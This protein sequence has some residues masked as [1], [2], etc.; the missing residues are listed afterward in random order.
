LRRSPGQPPRR[1]EVP[2]SSQDI[3]PTLLR[4]LDEPGFESFLERSLGHDVLA[5][6][7]TPQPI[8]SQDTGRARD[9]PFKRAL[10]DRN[11]KYLRIEH[12]DGRIEERLFDLGVD[13]YE[14]RDVAT[15]H[16][17]LLESMRE[18]ALALID[19]HSRRG[20][21]LRAG[22]EQVV[23]QEAD[24]KLLRELCALGYL[25]P[26]RCAALESGSAG[27]VPSADSAVEGGDSS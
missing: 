10:V 5:D 21:A 9:E 8:L 6:D 17:E 18:R 14:L 1:I 7:F 27:S 22:A 26:E 13:P 2:L 20:E 11:Y 25:E 3:L 19:E 15:T 24:P 4:R 16:S 12:A 23:P